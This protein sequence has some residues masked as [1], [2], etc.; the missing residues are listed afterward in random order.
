MDPKTASRA[1]KAAATALHPTTQDT[2]RVAAS[3]GFTKMVAPEFDDLLQPKPDPETA[4]KLWE[5]E[6]RARLA[7]RYAAGLAEQ[8]ER[9]RVERA[10]RD[11]AA[12]S[13]QSVHNCRQERPSRYGV[14]H[15]FVIANRR[16]PEVAREYPWVEAVAPGHVYPTQANG[17]QLCRLAM[18]I[19]ESGQADEVAL[20][21]YLAAHGGWG[22]SMQAARDCLAVDRGCFM[23][24]FFQ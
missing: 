20:R 14:V 4:R 9:A 1:R 23:Q 17:E 2:E 8:A 19:L 13:P 15:A 7:E 21:R 11:A 3:V 6:Q 10:E 22:N 24:G 18:D 5:A 16:F 12:G